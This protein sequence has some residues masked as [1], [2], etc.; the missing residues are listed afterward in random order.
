MQIIYTSLDLVKTARIKPLALDH[1][2][3]SK[4]Y[5]LYEVFLYLTY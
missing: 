1:H 5:R 2:L 4:L 3:K